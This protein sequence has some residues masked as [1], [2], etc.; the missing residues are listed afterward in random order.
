MTAFNRHTGMEFF[1]NLASVMEKSAYVNY[2]NLQQFELK[3]LIKY[4]FSYQFQ[5]EDV[6][7]MVESGVTTIQTP[8]KIMCN[9]R[10]RTVGGVTSAEKGHLVTLA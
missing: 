5:P 7:N 10:R 1:N 8:Q 6:Y 4:D 9:T 2:L 3:Q